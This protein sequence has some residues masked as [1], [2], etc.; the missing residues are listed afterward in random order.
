M[1]PVAHFPFQLYCKQ[2]IT[3]FKKAKTNSNPALF[4]YK[5]NARK[6]LFMAES[7][8]R[9]SNKL[10]E[11]GDI[12]DWHA[13]IKKLENYLGA[14]DEYYTLL[15]EI[16][17]LKTVSLQQL[18]YISGKLNKAT[19][20]LNEKLRKRDFYFTDINEMSTGFKINFNDKAIVLK[21]QEEIKS[22]LF[23]AGEFFNQFAKGFNDMESQVHELRRK[24]RWISI[25]GESFDGLMVLQD[26]KEK[27]R[28]EKEFIT[29]VQIQN[30][31]NKLPVKKNLSQ[32][33]SINKKAF[34]ALSFVIENLGKIK[35]KS[36]ELYYLDKSIRK[37]TSEKG[38]NS[39]LLAAK[40]LNAK[41]TQASL[42]KDAHALLNDFFTKYKIHQ[43]LT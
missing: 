3:L 8:L 9:A 32:Y 34:Y 22:E 43:T 35:D 42:L 31:F 16:S 40:Q 27:Y 39:A 5:N 14:I 38:V 21:L 2:L 37:T 7:I 13:T 6:V 36:F 4:L 29:K 20:K 18:E 11:D 28:W 41:Y 25:Y 17:K 15:A 30:P 23:E 24:L 33:I 10:F 19:E 26:T 12:K 1:A